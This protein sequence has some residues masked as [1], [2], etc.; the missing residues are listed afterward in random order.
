MSSLTLEREVKLR[1]K[2]AE[3]ARKA[4]LDAGATPM[5]GRRL[6]E[7]SLLDN[8]DEQ[9]RRR[10]CVLRVRYSWE[11]PV[12][13]GSGGGPR[14]ALSLLVDDMRDT[15]LL[16]NGDTLTDLDPNALLDEHFASGAIVTMALIPNPRPD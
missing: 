3:E 4:I 13:L 10:R 15:C 16:V 11:Q 2:S 6:Q 14:H 12:V 1:F 5:L 7:D 8:D 9:L